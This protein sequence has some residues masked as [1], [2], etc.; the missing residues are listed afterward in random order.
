[1]LGVVVLPPPSN[2]KLKPPGPAGVLF[3]F[4]ALPAGVA[5]AE[6][7]SLKVGVGMSLLLLP[8]GV[9]AAKRP[10]PAG[11]GV[12]PALAVFGLGVPFA[13]AAGVIAVFASAQVTDFL[14]VLPP[15]RGAVDWSRLLLPPS[16]AAVPAMGVPK[17]MSEA[18]PATSLG[19][20]I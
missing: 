9:S 16:A 19:R 11:A 3:V 12:C 7:G 20:L 10:K 8:P 15:V 4:L 13:A 1:M 5:A 6:P 18:G 17:M 14:P 2:D